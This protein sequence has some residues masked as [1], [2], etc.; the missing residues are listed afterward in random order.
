MECLGTPL[1]LKNKFS[2]GYKLL[3][4][5]QEQNRD[6]VVKG[7]DKLFPNAKRIGMY[8]GTAEYS[9]AIKQGKVAATFETLLNESKNIG[10]SDWS[11]GQVSLE[12]VF[13]AVIHKSR[14][15]ASI[16]QNNDQISLIDD[17]EKF[18]IY[19]INETNETN[20]NEIII[21]QNN[22]TNNDNYNNNDDNKNDGGFEN[23]EE[24]DEEDDVDDDV[25]NNK[26]D[27]LNSGKDEL[28]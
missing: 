11:F 2:Q 13:S 3:V 27:N 24:E 4:N 22:N 15:N 19:E 16:G 1:R 14:K 17:D 25:D 10:V 8:K 18:D 7:I 21:D 12:S 28:N 6:K 5:F 23:E 20:Q 26:G 9:L